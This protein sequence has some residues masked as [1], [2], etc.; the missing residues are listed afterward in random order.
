MARG[1]SKRASGALFSPR[2]LAGPGKSQVSLP[3]LAFSGTRVQTLTLTR[4][5]GKS[6]VSLLFLAFL[7][8]RKGTRVQEY[9]H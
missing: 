9:K 3:F 7:C 6:S 4:L 2:A 1:N 5:P 8:T